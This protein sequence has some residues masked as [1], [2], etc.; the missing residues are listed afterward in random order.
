VLILYP[1]TDLE[2]S[3]SSTLDISYKPLVAPAKQSPP[4]SSLFTGAWRRSSQKRSELALLWKPR[5]TSTNSHFSSFDLAARNVSISCLTPLPSTE[6]SLL[7]PAKSIF[8]SSWH[9]D[10]AACACRHFSEDF[11]NS[12]RWTSKQYVA[13]NESIYN[14]YY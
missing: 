1:D 13:C 4:S 11:S 2:T 14:A 3:L 12:P 8:T 6:P 10:E 5:K 9:N 7:A